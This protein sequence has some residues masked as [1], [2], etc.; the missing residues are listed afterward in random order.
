[1]FG[2][3]VVGKLV[4]IIRYVFDQFVDN[5]DLIIEDFYRKMIIVKGKKRVVGKGNLGILKNMIRI[6]KFKYF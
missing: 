2:L 5:Y 1:M 6:K 3:G 4:L